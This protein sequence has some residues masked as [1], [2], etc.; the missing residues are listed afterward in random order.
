MFKLF[1]VRNLNFMTSMNGIAAVAPKILNLTPSQLQ[2]QAKITADILRSG[3]VVATPTDTIY[4]LAALAN[5]TKAVRKIYD[6]KGRN[7]SK[8]I[9]ICV[10]NVKEV[11]LWGNVTISE[12]LLE[13]LLPGPVTLCFKRSENL[14]PELN[15]DSPIVGIRIPDHPFIREVC[16]LTQSPLAL[17]SANIS[18]GKSTLAVEEFSELYDHLSLIVKCWRQVNPQQMSMIGCMTYVCITFCRV[19]ILLAP[20]LIWQVNLLHQPTK[21]IE[22]WLKYV[23]LSDLSS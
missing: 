22:K 14:N 17:T 9:S 4:G 16:R 20:V 12:T 18:Q 1:A 6:I 8:P 15:P 3:E 19:F 5:T 21:T 10:S 23:V 11:G 2:Q 13:H 7:Q